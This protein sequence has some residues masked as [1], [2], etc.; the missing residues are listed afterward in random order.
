VP[1]AAEDVAAVP[2]AQAAAE[3]LARFEAGESVLAESDLEGTFV[4]RRAGEDRLHAAFP[5]TAD[6]PFIPA[7]TFKIPNTLVGLETG[8]IPDRNFALPWD[9]VERSVAAWNRDQD[10]A[11]AMAESTV[12]FYQEIARRVGPE[13]MADWVCR[14]GYGNADLGD[15][16]DEFWLV[17]PLAISPRQQ[18]EFLERLTAGELPVAARSVEILRSVMPRRSMPS[19]EV[20]A[21]TGTYASG[22]DCHAWLVGWVERESAVASHF[23]LLLRCSPDAVPDRELRWELVGRLLEAADRE[24]LPGS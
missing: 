11:S 6:V 19:G 21:K 16:V 7:S 10:L 3:T 23:A 5:E 17:G 22:A 2:E 9:G 14:L 1:A 12:W 8:V 24:P 4:Y 13:R 18:V 15:R 20:L